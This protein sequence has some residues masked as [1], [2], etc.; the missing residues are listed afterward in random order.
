MT[1][2]GSPPPL[3]L[4]SVSDP[5][6]YRVRSRG[7][8]R[9]SPGTDLPSIPHPPSYPIAPPHLSRRV[10]SLQRPS[11]PPCHLMRGGPVLIST[12]EKERWGARGGSERLL[13]RGSPYLLISP[14][15]PYLSTL[16]CIPSLV[17]TLYLTCGGSREQWGGVVDPGAYPPPVPL[18]SL[19]APSLVISGALWPLSEAP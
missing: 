5:H 3:P 10:D 1:P 8:D 11:I 15:G 19:R 17:P 6:R 18:R 12:I 4:P 9:L 2:G 14:H 7:L 16:P 13:S